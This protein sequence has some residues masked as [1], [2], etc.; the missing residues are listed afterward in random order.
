MT[1][2]L[3]NSDTLQNIA[4]S[5]KA[6]R[7]SDEKMLPSEMPRA[8]DE[9]STSSG[10]GVN[11]QEIMMQLAD[12]SYTFGDYIAK[13][14]AINSNIYTNQ[15]SLHSYMN[16]N[17]T[18]IN[19]DGAFQNCFYL[20][21]VNIPRLTTL[22]KTAT[23]SGCSRLTTIDIGIITALPNS[24]F[25]ACSPLKAV[26][27]ADMVTSVGQQ[28]FSF[29][30]G[31]KTLYLPVC[32]NILPFAFAQTSI[33]HAILPAM[34]NIGGYIFASC[35]LLEKVDIGD[36]CQSINNQLFSNSQSQI[37]L[38]IRTENP[39]ALNGVFLFGKN[40][41]IKSIKVP[42]ESVDKYKAAQ[43]WKNY[44]DIITVITPEDDY[45][46]EAPENTHTE[47]VINHV[48][49]RTQSVPKYINSN[50]ENITVDGAFLNNKSLLTFYAP[51]LNRTN[52]YTFKGCSNLISVNIDG[53]EQLPN[54]FF[55]GCN[56]L[57]DIPNKKYITFIGEANF[58]HNKNFVNIDLPQCREIQWA[59]FN[60]CS[61]LETVT[62]PAAEII[63][64]TVF[65][66]CDK[67][68]LVD[69]GE[70]TKYIHCYV[71]ENS[72]CNV[73]LIIRATTPPELAGGNRFIMGNQGTLNIKVPA[74]AVDAYKAAPNWS[75][76]AGLISAI[77]N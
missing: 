25:Y 53:L 62:L 60:S 24:T 14:T 71:F 12:K 77:S 73:T 13:E 64:N 46:P 36:K 74:E 76:N 68:K 2:V 56:K 1:M 8:I 67:L 17:L 4:D 21:N 33:R 66:S 48:N 16:D 69:L 11:A 35:G 18:A 45:T 30:Q 7:G 51:N 26:P 5:I 32:E 28:C 72:N 39:P 61:N 29:N 40:G 10:E 58:A 55:D 63:R 57:T 3:I 22:T 49:Y 9:I 54:G 65:A 70:N 52:P 15:N 47:V 23:F 34:I 27:N 37:D 20:T 42:A 38:I 59:A 19:I 75:N 41:K 31:I 44:I 50:L 6:K 43:N